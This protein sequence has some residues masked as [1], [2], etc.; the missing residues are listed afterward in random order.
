MSDIRHWVVSLVLFGVWTGGVAFGE[1]LSVAEFSELA[2][3][4]GSYEVRAYVVKQ[5]RCPPCPKGALCKPCMPDNILIADESA[6]Q[7]TYPDG[8]NF[9]V[10]ITPEKIE[11]ELGNLYTL[12]VKVLKSKSTNRNLPD[13]QLQ[14]II[15]N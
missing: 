7:Q 3:A 13:L 6:V 4:V 14:A 11:V 12:M 2:P 15:L 1:S 10:V 5:Y 8:G 9:L